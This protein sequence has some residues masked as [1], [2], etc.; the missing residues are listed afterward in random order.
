MV[1]RPAA[2]VHFIC[3]YERFGCVFRPKPANV[4]VF[5]AHIFFDDCMDLDDEDKWIPNQFV[6]Q[7]IDCIE[8]A[9]R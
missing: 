3:K 7:F 4:C 9:A 2:G 5:A 1:A 6:I 8:H